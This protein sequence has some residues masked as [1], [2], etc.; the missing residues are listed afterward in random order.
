MKFDAD[1]L[2][3]LS[4]HL[5]ESI[6]APEPERSSRLALIGKTAPDMACRHADLLSRQAALETGDF[7]ATLPKFAIEDSL[8]TATH[9]GERVGPYEVLRSWAKAA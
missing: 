1:G 9:I 6:E 4:E 2:R 8:T 5:D 7:M 3:R